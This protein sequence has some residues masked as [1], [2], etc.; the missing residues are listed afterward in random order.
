M[1]FML[2]MFCFVISVINLPYNLLSLC[3]IFH[4]SPFIGDWTIHSMP[5]SK[6]SLKA[7]GISDDSIYLNIDILCRIDIVQQNIE[8]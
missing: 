6:L 7:L 8:F 2:M 5:L 4:L 1:L 3:A